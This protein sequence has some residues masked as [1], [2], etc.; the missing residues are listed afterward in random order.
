MLLR[1]SGGGVLG[2]ASPEVR[3]RLSDVLRSMADYVK[4]PDY[5]GLLGG[6]WAPWGQA[7]HFMKPSGW[8]SKDALQFGMNLIWNSVLEAVAHFRSNDMGRAKLRLADAL[9]ALQDSFSPAHVK[10]VRNQ[11]GI[12]VIKDI[13]EYTAQ[14][15][16]EHEKGDETY[17]TGPGEESPYS[18]LG[19]AT[20]LASTL[21]LSYFIQ[22]CL[23]RAGDAAG[24][25]TSLNDLYL[26]A[27]LS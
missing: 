25:R 26:R 21:L 16:K 15:S 12:W 17:R 5:A 7:Q 4:T 2:Q 10:R 18:G 11:E 22:C 20:V 9:H 3:E 27:E 23:G 14:D 1:A 6:H 13:Y 24:I 8:P 19:Q